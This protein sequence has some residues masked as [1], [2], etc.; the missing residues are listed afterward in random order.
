[1]SKRLIGLGL[2]FIL[3]LTAI[4][5]SAQQNEGYIT[6]VKLNDGSV[7]EGQMTEYVDGEYIKMNIGESQIT[8]KQSSIRSITHKNLSN[9]RQYT[10]REIGYYHHSSIGLMPGFISSGNAVLGATLD[11]SSGYLFNR[12]A[13]AGLNLGIMN[14]DLVSGE[15][16]YS[17]AAE[18]RGYLLNQYFSP[19][20][21]VR[22]GYGFNFKGERFLDAEGGLFLN[23]AIGM[24]LTGK[25]SVNV[26]VEIGISFQ[27]AYYQYETQ[28]WDQ[29]IIEK[30]V[31][32]QRFTM[33]LGVLF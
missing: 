16:I 25:Q 32:Y 26:T 2:F 27:N 18:F 9:I 14:Y 22:S 10:F 5:A 17:L 19:Y 4:T 8:I 11:H 1:M 24:R 15:A 12:F 31:R 6:K 28:W 7:L 3:L 29:S 20:Y 13:G 33:K 21:L 30:D 23:P